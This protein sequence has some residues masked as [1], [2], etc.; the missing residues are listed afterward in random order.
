MNLKRVY[1]PWD[2][3]GKELADEVAFT[4]PESRLEVPAVAREILLFLDETPVF[5]RD[6]GVVLEIK[7]ALI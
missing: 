6:V 2:E 1:I 5:L 3:F 7:N 4:T